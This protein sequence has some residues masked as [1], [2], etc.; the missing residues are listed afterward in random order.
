MKL[1]SFI[2][3]FGAL[4]PFAAL[5]K[6]PAPKVKADLVYKT[7]KQGPLHLDLYYPDTEVEAG[8]KLPIAIY[9]HGGGWAAGSKKAAAGGNHM[10]KVVRGLTARGFCVASIEY[11]LYKKDSD[12]TIKD[13][14]TDSKDAIRYLVKNN[15]ELSINP[16]CV[17]TFGD[18]AGG[19]IAQMLLLSSPESLPGAEELAGQNYR[20]L[21]GVTWYGP[22]D[23]EKTEL[24]NHNGRA[25]FR[26]RFGPRILKPDA[27][28]ENKVALYREMSPIQ[29]LKSDS[30]PLLM[31]QGDGDTTIPVHHAHYMKERAEAISAPVEI[32]II[33]GA[34]HNWRMADGETPIN[35]STDVIVQRTIEFFEKHLPKQP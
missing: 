14:V 30:P 11:R 15:E 5:A 13:C 29:Y 10:G 28:P 23:F 17:F 1:T 6:E 20:T 34:G 19:Q 8:T 33:K 25:D 7:S 9:T 12:I 24:F 26:D 32:L 31:I 2:L 4:L 16:N 21:A 27:K 3:A 35:P 22:C 18:S